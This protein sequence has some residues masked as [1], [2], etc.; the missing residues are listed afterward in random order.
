[1]CVCVCVGGWEGDVFYT[2]TDSFIG[3]AAQSGEQHYGKGNAHANTQELAA[4]PALP[5]R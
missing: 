2:I 5:V 4:V 3:C 1:M